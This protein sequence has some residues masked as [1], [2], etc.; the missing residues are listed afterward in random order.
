MTL[1]S[2]EASLPSACLVEVKSCR[3]FSWNQVQI[4]CVIDF[5]SSDLNAEPLHAVI[6]LPSF[7]LV[8]QSFLMVHAWKKN[9]TED[10]R[11]HRPI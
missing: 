11:K 7:L 4:L 5:P 3:S 10:N 2:R 9:N 1:Q 6:R 8:F